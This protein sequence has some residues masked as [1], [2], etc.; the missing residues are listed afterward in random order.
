MTGE[1][2]VEQICSHSLSSQSQSF[3]NGVQSRD[4][5]C[6]I[7]RVLNTMAPGCWI[8]FQTAHVFPLEHESYW[9]QG[10]F[11][12][13]ITDMDG[14][15]GETRINSVQN[16]LLM[17]N[18]LYSC[19]DNNMFSIN[20]DVCI[21]KLTLPFHLGLYYSC[22]LTL[23][24]TGIKIVSFAQD[25]WGVDGRVLDPVCRDPRDPHCVSDELLRWHFRQSVFANVRGAGEPVF[26]EDYPLET[27]KMETLPN[28]PYGEGR[29]ELELALTLKPVVDP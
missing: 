28:E 18:N 4:G 8:G 13:W 14:I 24:R 7:S 29:L 20:P 19:F 25:L 17:S 9:V 21:S 16:G 3:Q 1:P 5:K 26:E 12:Q 10:S 15:I 11:A 22:K 2:W 27:E 6:V 23:S